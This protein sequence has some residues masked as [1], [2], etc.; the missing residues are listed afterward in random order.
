MAANCHALPIS[1]AANNYQ[2]IYCLCFSSTNRTQTQIRPQSTQRNHVKITH[3]KHQFVVYFV[4]TNE[5]RMRFSVRHSKKNYIFLFLMVKREQLWISVNRFTHIKVQ[6]SPLRLSLDW[7]H[8]WIN[9]FYMH[10]HFGSLVRRVSS[11]TTS[12]CVTIVVV[13]YHS[14]NY[15]KNSDMLDCLSRLSRF[16]CRWDFRPQ[17]EPNVSMVRR[18]YETWAA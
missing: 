11:T 14:W 6:I 9:R 2:S 18:V 8:I 5:I 13:Y 17:G 16:I 7:I 3:D 10:Q 1:I 15:S 12:T 4:Q